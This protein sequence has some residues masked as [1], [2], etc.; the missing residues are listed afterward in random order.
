M[1]VSKSICIICFHYNTFF[2]CV[3]QHV[4]TGFASWNID[5]S[6]LPCFVW[7]NTNGCLAGLDRWSHRR[8]SDPGFD[9]RWERISDWA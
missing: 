8:S 1:L 2:F 3:L 5:F 9:F 6:V 4:L 7:I